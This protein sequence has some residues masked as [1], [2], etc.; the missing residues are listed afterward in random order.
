MVSEYW[1]AR[2]WHEVADPCL[3][4]PMAVI[5]NTLFFV[6]EPAIL[7]NCNVVRPYRWFLQGGSIMARAWPLRAVKQN[8][9][10]GW[11]IEEFQTIVVTQA[12]LSISFVSWGDGQVSRTLPSPTCIFG[13]FELVALIKS[14]LN[15]LRL[16][17][18]A[19]WSCLPLDTD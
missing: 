13:T 3:V 8:D 6:Y 12:E 15:H 19:S 2:H 11:I 17:V 10:T 1:H 16:H 9:V 4:T 14:Y 18:G 7:T 5:N